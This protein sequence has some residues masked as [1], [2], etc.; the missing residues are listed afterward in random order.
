MMM[1][2][3]RPVRL[4]VPAVDGA[5]WIR[6]DAWAT[7]VF[8][9]VAVGGAAAPSVL[10]V[11]AAA[12]S[13]ILFVVG[14]VVFLVAFLRGVDRSRTEEISVAELFLLMGGVA[15][16]VVRRWLLG[17][18]GVQVVVAIAVA[19]IRPFTSLAFGILTP[20]FGLAIAGRWAAEYG[21]FRAR[22]VLRT[23]RTV[24]NAQPPVNE[25]GFPGA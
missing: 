24:T 14:C 16:A 8:A 3:L 25:E 4:G 1:P 21:S 11:A 19:S 20:M 18:L 15:P 9:V 23:K 10:G 17:L 2:V 22:T 13:I 6:L 12:V 7:A 5:G